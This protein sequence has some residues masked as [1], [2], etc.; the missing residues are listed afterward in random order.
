MPY[1]TIING[2]IKS[3]YTKPNPL[4]RLKS[5]ERMVKYD[6]PDLDL[7]YY[8]VKPVTPVTGRFVQFTITEKPEANQLKTENL[9][10]QVDSQVDKLYADAI[11]NF[12]LEYQQAES[13][14]QIYR[15]TGY[16]GDIPETLRGYMAAS[17]LDAKSAADK[18]LELAANWRSI[19]QVVRAERLAA[20]SRIRSGDFDTETWDNFLSV[21]RKGLGL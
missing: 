1:A 11:G 14:A 20:K 8:D 21:T 9:L 3:I 18:T 4:V 17:G 15:D 10:K 6:P 19:L 12:G 2:Q 16:N 13:D 5:D 7:N